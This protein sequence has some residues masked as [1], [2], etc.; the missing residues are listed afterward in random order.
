V[1]VAAP[2]A[3]RS[4]SA[5]MSRAQALAHLR[6]AFADAGLDNAALDARIL[7][8][9]ALGVAP[10]ALVTDPDAPLGADGAER[11]AK[12]A[13]RRLD[14]EPVAR[15]LGEREFWGL[16]FELSP[17]TLVPRPDTETL[18]RAA[19][20]RL[21]DRRKGWRILDLGTGTGCLLVAL[22]SELPSARGIGADRSLDALRTALRN[23]ARNDVGERASFVASDWADACEGAFDLIVSN[24][25][26]I[27]TDDL[28]HLDPEVREHDPR[29]ALDGGKDGLGAYRAIFR[30]APRLLRPD[31]WLV[32]ELGLGQEEEVRRIASSA[33]LEVAGIERDLGGRPRAVSLRR[34]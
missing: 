13:R 27:P 5:R 33:R 4:I 10:A 30:D 31:A 32:V 34:L 2:A 22:L 6:R 15:I 26:Y 17:E 12:I 19:L 21:E 16:P 24:P 23:A 1:T 25:P 14:R 7:L 28:L 18:V 20:A 11:L 9:E 3:H 29:A 8:V